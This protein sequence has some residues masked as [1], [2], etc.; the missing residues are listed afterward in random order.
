MNQSNQHV[1]TAA[2]GELREVM[3]DEFDLLIEAFVLDARERLDELAGAVALA[4]ADL[5]RRAAHSLKG[6]CGNVGA[7]LL[8]DLADHTEAACRDGRLAEVPAMLPGLA[9]ELDLVCSLLQDNAA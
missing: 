1:D 4:D 8:A 6:S 5:A 3:E 2:L 7:V 9:G